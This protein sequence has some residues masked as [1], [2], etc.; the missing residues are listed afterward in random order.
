MATS[1]KTTAPTQSTQPTAQPPALGADT[2]APATPAA[3]TQQHPYRVGAVPI[4]HDGVL[5]PV[6]AAIALTTAQASRLGGLVTPE[7]H[8][9]KD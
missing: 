9:A 4:R 7:T 2:P 6:G 5:Y 3:L 8:P 1:K